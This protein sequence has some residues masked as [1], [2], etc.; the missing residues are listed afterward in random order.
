MSCEACR[1]LFNII[2]IFWFIIG[3]PANVFDGKSNK[4]LRLRNT[5]LSL[6]KGIK[7][8]KNT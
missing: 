4:R 3:S 8:K 5:K 2:D 1:L 7:L 6:K